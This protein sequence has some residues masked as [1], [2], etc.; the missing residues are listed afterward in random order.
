MVFA[1]TSIMRYFTVCSSQ[2]S[3]ASKIFMEVPSFHH[4]AVYFIMVGVIPLIQSC[5]GLWVKIKILLYDNFWLL[6]K[7]GYISVLIE[8]S[9]K[10]QPSVTNLTITLMNESYFVQFE[11]CYPF[12][13]SKH[14]SD[15]FINQPEIT[16]LIVQEKNRDT[17]R[18]A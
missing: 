16:S 11:D 14:H 13:L 1:L 17:D 3:K 5:I 15:G 10:S 8:S 7:I 6:L 4:L 9:A 2:G 18:L 12:D